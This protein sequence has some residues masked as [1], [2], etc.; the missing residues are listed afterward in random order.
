MEK[1][2]V[3]SFI[4]VVL[5]IMTAL[6]SIFC[7]NLNPLHYWRTIFTLQFIAGFFGITAIIG[8]SMSGKQDSGVYYILIFLCIFISCVMSHILNCKLNRKT[9]KVRNVSER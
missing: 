8:M 4:L 1:L 9:D 6:L 3:I 5:S 7:N 2:T